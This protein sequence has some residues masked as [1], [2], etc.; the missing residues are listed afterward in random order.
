MSRLLVLGSGVLGGQVVD[1]LSMIPSPYTDIVVASRKAENAIRRVNLSRF[2]GMD[3]GRNPT[4]SVRQIDLR[5]IDATATLI[6]DVR[7]DVIFQ[8]ACIWSWWKI[9]ELPEELFCELDRA[10]VGPWLP[11]YLALTLNVMKAVRESGLHPQVVNGCYP[12]ANNPALASIDLP[13]LCGI[14]NVAR[15]VSIV[16]TAVADYLDLPPTM[17]D[18]RLYAEHYV[19]Y[20]LLQCP[21]PELLPKALRVLRAGVDIT[22]SLPIDAILREIPKRYP[23]VRGMAG[24]LLTATSAFNVLCALRSPKRRVEHTPG[25][26]GMVGGYPC[27]FADGRIRILLDGV[28]GSHAKEVN[29]HGLK[30]EGIEAIEPGGIIYFSK[31]NMSILHRVFGY[32]VAQ[33]RVADTWQHATELLD[34]YTKFAAQFPPRAVA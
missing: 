32:S 9:R 29:E 26:L 27:E 1:L 4:C 7:P 6:R 17:I 11:L 33:M 13:P 8:S 23:R 20:Q 14:G 3:L 2:A 25:P 34:R 10:G 19:G 15:S 24:Q 28:S 21:S 12:D 5:N 18:I 22:D 16:R 30:L 31:A